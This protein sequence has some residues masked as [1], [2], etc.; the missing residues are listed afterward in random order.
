MKTIITTLILIIICATG[1]IST[2]QDMPLEEEAYVD[3]IPFNTE[4]IAYQSMVNNMISTDIE[5]YVDDIPFNTRKIFYESLANNMVTA[6][7]DEAYADDIPFCTNNIYCMSKP[8]TMSQSSRLIS[9]INGINEFINSY[10]GRNEIIYYPLDSKKGN[11][12]TSEYKLES[13]LAD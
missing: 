13:L 12:K 10:Y 3:D 1:T 8:C 5:S 7:S 6:S 2:G 4:L 11:C 9:D